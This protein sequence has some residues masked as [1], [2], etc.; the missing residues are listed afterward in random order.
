MATVTGDLELEII[1]GAASS[2]VSAASGDVVVSA[3]HPTGRRL[4][5]QRM[6]AFRMPKPRAGTRRCRSFS[7]GWLVPTV[8]WP[9]GVRP[10]DDQVGVAIGAAGWGV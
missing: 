8:R 1:C 6:Q 4:A 5:R 3:A 2:A 10:R 9:A 7:E